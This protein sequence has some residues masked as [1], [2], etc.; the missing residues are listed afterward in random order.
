MCGMMCGGHDAHLTHEC[1]GSQQ[2]IAIRETTT[3]RRWLEARHGVARARPG[4][5]LRHV[6][7]ALKTRVTSDTR[8][9]RLLVCAFARTR[10]STGG[11]AVLD[12]VF[13]VPP[14]PSW[15]S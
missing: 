1:P 7:W 14:A 9:A 5:A 15:S 10:R 3:R 11:L 12:S 4:C 13:V 2:G 6:I 8:F